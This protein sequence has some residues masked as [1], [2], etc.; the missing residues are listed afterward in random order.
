MTG[1]M[2]RTQGGHA[3]ESH[4]SDLNPGQLQRGQGLCTWDA[5]STN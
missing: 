2:M 4:G 1:N 3:A 5:H